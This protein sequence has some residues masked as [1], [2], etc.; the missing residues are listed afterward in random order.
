MDVPATVEQATRAATA[1]GF[2][3]SCDPGVGRLLSVLATAVKPGGAIL[4]LGTGAGV[5]VA[6]I[7]AGLAG[8]TDVRVV[9]IEL[10]PELGA[11]ATANEWPDYVQLEVGDARELL[12]PPE[13]WDLIVAD[14]PGGKWEGLNDTIEALEPGGVL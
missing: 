10:D 9:S 2:S 6:W 14:S 7:V 1:A 4:E 12:R 8:R 3:L 5:G 13:R 11:V